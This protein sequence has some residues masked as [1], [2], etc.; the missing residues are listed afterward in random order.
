MEVHF[1]MRITKISHED[2]IAH[3]V[4]LSGHDS[5]N[6]KAELKRVYF[7]AIDSIVSSMKE[8]LD[9]KTES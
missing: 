8:R 1:Q 7:G 3:D 5:N 4:A 6:L 9:K 2:F